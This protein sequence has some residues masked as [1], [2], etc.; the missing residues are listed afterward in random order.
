M[1]RIHFGMTVR[2]EITG[3]SDNA[4]AAKPLDVRVS[5]RPQFPK[6]GAG[7]ENWP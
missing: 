5:P 6:K 7:D 1:C 2:M 3:E 4:K